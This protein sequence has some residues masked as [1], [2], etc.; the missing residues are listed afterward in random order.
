MFVLILTRIKVMEKFQNIDKTENQEV[1]KKARKKL[2]QTRLHL[3]KAILKIFG[4][5][6]QSKF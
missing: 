4:T 5:V 6:T 3:N 2:R 1:T